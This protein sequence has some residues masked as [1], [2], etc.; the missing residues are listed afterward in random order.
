MDRGYWGTNLFCELKQDYAVDFVSRVRNQNLEIN[1]HIQRQVQEPGRRWT[2]L[3]EE[4]QFSGRL[5]QQQVRLTALRPIPCRRR[6]KRVPVQRSRGS[7]VWGYALAC[8]GAQK[9][10]RS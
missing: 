10:G 3:D 1:G 9:E 2:T 4:R 8:G 7:Q 5:E 6:R